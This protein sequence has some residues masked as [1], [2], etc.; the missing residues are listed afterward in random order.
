MKTTTFYNLGE[1]LY[2]RC[3]R[4]KVLAD[5]R[6]HPWLKF[7]ATEQESINTSCTLLSRSLPGRF[8]AT[9]FLLNGR[10]FEH[11]RI[12]FL[13]MSRSEFRPLSPFWLLF[14]T[15]KSNKGRR[16]GKTD[17]FVR[18]SIEAYKINYL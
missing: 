12:Q 15:T 9:Q 3:N 4:T 7:G 2:Q 5:H 8:T 13:R 18:Y 10:V 14:V 16:L 6:V 11:R 17:V 1:A